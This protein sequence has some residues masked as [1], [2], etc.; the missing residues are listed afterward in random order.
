MPTVQYPFFVS[1]ASNHGID[2]DTRK[3]TLQIQPPFVIPEQATAARAFVHSATVPYSFPNVSSSTN[4]LHIG[5]PS[6]TDGALESLTVRI[7]PGNYTLGSTD[8]SNDL[9]SVINAAVHQAASA[10][11]NTN[12]AYEPSMQIKDFLTITPNFGLGRVDITL[13]HAPSAI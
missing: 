5:V 12:A 2:A 6:I 10:K 3:F 1:S 4:T 9:Q 11:H 7:P 13:H 8:P